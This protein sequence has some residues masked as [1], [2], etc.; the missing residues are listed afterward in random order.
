MT[1]ALNINANEED[2]LWRK[3]LKCK[4][5]EVAVKEGGPAIKQLVN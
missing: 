1:K 5:Y 2:V 3:I 4:F